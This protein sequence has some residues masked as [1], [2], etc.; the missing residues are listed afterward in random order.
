MGSYRT[1]Q[2]GIAQVVQAATVGGG[3]VLMMCRFGRPEKS[4]SD[5][6]S[7]AAGAVVNWMPLT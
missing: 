2:T 4:W 7:A 6:R 3:R 1:S 5:T